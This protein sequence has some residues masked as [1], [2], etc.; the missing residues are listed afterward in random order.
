MKSGVHDSSGSL[1]VDLQHPRYQYDLAV[2]NIKKDHFGDLFGDLLGARVVVAV[3]A[4]SSRTG[5]AVLVE[6][7]TV[8]HPRYSLGGWS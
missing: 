2:F 6:N 8:A 3:S 4:F 7:G 5:V 1:T